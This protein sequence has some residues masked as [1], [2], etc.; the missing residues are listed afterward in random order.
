MYVQRKRVIRHAR[1]VIR[2]MII[3]RVKKQILFRSS[4]TIASRNVYDISTPV[5]VGNST[6]RGGRLLTE[7]D[8]ID[9]E[10]RRFVIEFSS[11]TT[12][13]S[14]GGRRG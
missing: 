7:L 4:T 2:S 13:Y 1:A 8:G 10:N 9:G 14:V 5:D 6:R 3:L 12:G 11:K